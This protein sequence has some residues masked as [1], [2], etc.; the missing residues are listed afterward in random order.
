LAPSPAPVQSPAER[1]KYRSPPPSGYSYT[2]TNKPKNKAPAAPAAEPIANNH[3]YASPPTMSHALPPSSISPSPS[4][5]CSINNPNRHHS[6]HAPS[7]ASV[8]SPLRAISLAH[9]HHPGQVQAVAPTPA[10]NTCES[11]LSFNIPQLPIIIKLKKHLSRLGV[12]RLFE[13]KAILLVL[14]YADFN[15]HFSCLQIERFSY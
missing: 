2:Y 15:N 10:P 11:C 7:P 13:K 9:P 5:R 3:H 14:S 6:S 1:F 4:G 8:K 12:G